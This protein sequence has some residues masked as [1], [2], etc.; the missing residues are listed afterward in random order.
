MRIGRALRPEFAAWRYG[1]QFGRRRK[2][3]MVY[4]AAGVT[5]LG[6]VAIGGAFAGLAMGPFMAQTGNL[7]RLWQY[8]RKPVKV[9]TAGG[10]VLKLSSQEIETAR[11]ER[12][13]DGWA[14]KLKKGWGRKALEPTFAGDEGARV[15]GLLLTRINHTGGSRDTVR[16]AVREIEQHGHPEAFLQNAVR[17]I[18]DGEIGAAGRLVKLPAP[19]RLALEMAL[20]EERE[21]RA[22]EGELRGLEIIWRREEEI[23]AISDDLL[24]PEKALTRLE[25]LRRAEG[26][27]AS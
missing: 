2:R 15:A 7:W 19:T 18:G 26:G 16:D 8:G 21:R 1:D 27:P 6:A 9:V 25:S 22:L 17:R 20:H 3:A 23:A 12:L 4:G 14:L 5:V 11:I 24:L 10:D 13:N